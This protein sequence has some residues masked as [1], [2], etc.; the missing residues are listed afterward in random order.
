MKRITDMLAKEIVAVTEGESAG[1]V[2]SAFTDEKL[3]RIRGYKIRLYTTSA[4][5]GWIRG[6]LIR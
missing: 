2:I 1:V 3:S 4:I 6:L 5:N